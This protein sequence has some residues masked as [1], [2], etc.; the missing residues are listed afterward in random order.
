M[1]TDSR[2]GLR[3]VIAMVL[4]GACWYVVGCD[5]G[6]DG[7]KDTALTATLVETHA[8]KTQNAQ[9]VLK[10]NLLVFPY[11]FGLYIWPEIFGVNDVRSY[12]MCI[13]EW[14]EEASWN[15]G[16]DGAISVQ[17]LWGASR[18]SVF[19]VGAFVIFGDPFHGELRWPIIERFDGENWR[20]ELIPGFYALQGTFSSVRGNDEAVF[21]VGGSVFPERT[22][23]LSQEG[24]DGWVVDYEKAGGAG[25]LDDVWVDSDG[26][27]FSVGHLGS[28]WE[29]EPFVVR[30]VG[31]RWIE[32]PFPALW[33][34]AAFGVWGSDK[35]NVWIAGSCYGDETA[36]L[37]KFDGTNFNEIGG[38]DGEG[39]GWKEIVGDAQSGVFLGS[40]PSTG[41]PGLRSAVFHFDGEQW[42]DM[43]FPISDEQHGIDSMWWS[44]NTGLYVTQGGAVWNY[45]FERWNMVESPYV[46]LLFGFDRE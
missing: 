17:G 30:K 28:C 18:E 13:G 41:N 20:P 19:L 45:Y 8:E 10:E 2:L 38:P 46:K 23:V 40:G 32:R 4:L 1:V 14:I 24:E 27:V 29:C 25:I 39:L 16:V 31:R 35:N 21:V 15:V 6:T 36:V 44:E 7:R 22:F 11:G 37:M 9:R 5:V 34:C 42:E 43:E 26:E 12:R 3:L 33:G